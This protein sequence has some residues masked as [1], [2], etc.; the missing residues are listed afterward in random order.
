MQLEECMKFKQKV[1]ML[2]V[3]LIVDMILAGGAVRMWKGRGETFDTREAKQVDTGRIPVSDEG[4]TTEVSEHDHS[5]AEQTERTVS[6]LSGQQEKRAKKYTALT[7]DDGPNP[8]YTKPLLDGL[9]ERGIRVTFFLVGECID[10]NEDLVK[11]MAKDGHLIGVHCMTHKDLTKEKLSDAAKELWAAREKIRA[12]TGTLPEYVRPPYGNWNAKLEEAVDMIPVFWDVDSIDW[13][14]KNTEKVTAKV[15]KDTEDGD[16]ILMH[17]EFGTSVE[18]AFQII[19]NLTAKGYTF[20]T[21]D[22]L[23][24][25]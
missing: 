11:Q 22:E 18:A 7:F 9:R 15:V 14:L 19:D 25:D 16:I 3:I 6:D 12:V 13:R 10:G 24:V 20:V 4:M 23:M 1:F 2:F 8:K 17:D 5:G 21:V